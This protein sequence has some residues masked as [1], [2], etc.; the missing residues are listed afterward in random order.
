V[1]SKEVGKKY[2]IIYADP[3]WDYVAGRPMDGS[4]GI[5][6]HYD[7]LKIHDLCSL[8]IGSLA[9]ENCVLFMWVT[10]PVLK[11]AFNV[12]EAWGFR[13]ATV[14]FTWV[15]ETRDG[16][17]YE[18]GLGFYT[19]ANAELCLI[20]RKTHVPERQSRSVPQIVF[21][22]RTKHSEKPHVV[23]ERIVELYGNLPRIELFSRH[24]VPGWDRH[25]IDI[26]DIR[27]FVPIHKVHRLKF[28]CD[29][30]GKYMDFVA[31]DDEPFYCSYC[32][33][34]WVVS[35]KE[36]ELKQYEAE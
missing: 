34:L 18:M 36:G 24:V 14:G 10:Y 2:S 9:T 3:P 8:D 17:L 31:R 25:G 6:D 4:K 33:K 26:G 22:P 23:R 28:Q 5:K 19:R 16:N 13:Y 30:C 35:D 29:A 7:C 21:A 1:E 32:D 27:D 11:E 12:M 15:K 20:G